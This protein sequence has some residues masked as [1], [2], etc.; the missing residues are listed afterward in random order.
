MYRFASTQ[1]DHKLA[2]KWIT[3]LENKTLGTPTTTPEIRTLGTPTTKPENKILGTP[4]T[5]LG[6]KPGTPKN[7]IRKKPRTPITTQNKLV[8]PSTTYSKRYSLAF[9]GMICSRYKSLIH[10]L[11][12]QNGDLCISIRSVIKILKIKQK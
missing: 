1:K 2:Q 4:T 10:A 3:T 8:V 5:T 9:S 11:L 6:K 7:H 12:L